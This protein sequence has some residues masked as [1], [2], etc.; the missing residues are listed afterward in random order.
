MHK[1]SVPLLGVE[2][3]L[4]EVEV[5]YSLH[6]GHP[7]DIHLTISYNLVVPFDQL[8][9]HLDTLASRHHKFIH[10][11]LTAHHSTRQQVRYATAQ[12]GNKS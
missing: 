10:N 11:A 3:W 9:T 6:S 2:K 7:L 8:H 4:P 1:A 5:D 12:L